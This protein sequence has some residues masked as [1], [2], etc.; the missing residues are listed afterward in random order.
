MEILYA[1]KCMF[2]NYINFNGRLSRPGYWWAY[3]GFVIINLIIS[4]LSVMLEIPIISMIVSIVFFLPL[5]SSEVRRFHDI[6]KSGLAIFIIAALN[7]VSVVAT[8]FALVMIIIFAFANDDTQLYMYVALLA[9][10]VLTT[11]G[12]TIYKIIMLAKQSDGPN[13]YGDP[14]EFIIPENFKLDIEI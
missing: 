1:L 2:E 3:L 8:A 10:T 7:I 6:G 11:I 13:Q 12:T 5:L 4:S 14:I 9:I